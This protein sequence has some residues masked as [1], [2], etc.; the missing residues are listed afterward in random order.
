MRT[1]PPVSSPNENEQRPA[2]MA[3]AEPPLEPPGTWSRSHGLCVLKKAEFSQEEPMPNSSML[4]LP[5]S[6]AP[7]SA[8]LF[9]TVA[10][11]CGTYSSRIFDEQVVRTARVEMQSLI[12]KGM[13]VR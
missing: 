8:S 11:Y 13:P 7:A 1:D 4:V 3:A 9:T 5:M 10:L 6:T 12:A 2:D